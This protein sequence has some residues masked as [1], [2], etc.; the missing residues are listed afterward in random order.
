[1]ES[2]RLME[3]EIRRE[4]RQRRRKLPKPCRHKTLGIN[5][6]RDRCTWIS[7]AHCGV[8]GPKKHSIALALCA[9]I[10]F[11]ANDHPKR[12]KS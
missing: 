6:E 10:L 9:W 3:E 5:T 1:M 12:R 8:K 7:C 4:E 11:I 2:E